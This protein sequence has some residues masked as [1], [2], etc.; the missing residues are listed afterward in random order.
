LFLFYYGEIN[1]GQTIF[2]AR[3]KNPIFISLRGPK[4]LDN[5]GCEEHKGKEVFGTWLLL[6]RPKGL[7]LEG[8]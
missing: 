2:T 4:A 7:I 1:A 6:E 8:N 3:S 5:K